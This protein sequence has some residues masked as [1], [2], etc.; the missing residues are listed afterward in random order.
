MARVKRGRRAAKQDE[1]DS[2]GGGP[3]SSGSFDTGAVAEAEAN[4][5][6]IDSLPDEILLKVF[7]HLST[8]GAASDQPPWYH[9][10][11]PFHK[12][13]WQPGLGAGGSWSG[14]VEGQRG[15]RAYPFLAQVCLRWKDVLEGLPGKRL[16]KEVTVDFGHEIVTS[17]HCP[18]EWSNRRPTESEFRESFASTTLSANKVCSSRHLWLFFGDQWGREP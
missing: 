13:E 17:I 11:F 16:W 7:S 1:A 10:E 5:A 6:N 2:E 12:L 14:G 18:L 8:V 4:R 15:L 3:S 9:D